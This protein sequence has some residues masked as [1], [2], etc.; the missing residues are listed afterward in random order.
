[1]P[2]IEQYPEDTRVRPQIPHYQPSRDERWLDTRLGKTKDMI[3][4]HHITP[5]NLVTEP[6]SHIKVCGC[7]NFY[8]GYCLHSMAT[9]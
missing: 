3:H 9:L 6:R 7:M 4:H 1:M 2:E 5:I 8:G